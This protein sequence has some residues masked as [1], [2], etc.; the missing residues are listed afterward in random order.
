MRSTQTDL[1]VLFTFFH[2]IHFIQVYFITD[3]KPWSNYTTALQSGNKLIICCPHFCSSTEQ[4]HPHTPCISTFT[5]PTVSSISWNYLH[6]MLR[7]R[8]VGFWYFLLIHWEMESK[9]KNPKT[10]QKCSEQ[11]TFQGHPEL[12]QKESTATC[13][14]KVLQFPSVSGKKK[15]TSSPGFLYIL[16]CV[17]ITQSAI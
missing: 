4:I 3:H 12:L 6:L 9:P 2:L 7:N 5:K 11:F 15:K 13:P 8:N 17:K 1:N 10:P 16:T 14:F